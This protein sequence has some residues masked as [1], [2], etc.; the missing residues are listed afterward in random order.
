MCLLLTCTL[1]IIIPPMGKRNRKHVTCTSTA[2]FS[3]ITGAKFEIESVR[4]T[5][6]SDTHLRHACATRTCALPTVLLK[7]GANAHKKYPPSVETIF[8]LF[9]A[10]SSFFIIQS[11]SKLQKI[12]TP[13]QKKYFSFSIL[14]ISNIDSNRHPFGKG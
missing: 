2:P 4:S 6:A 1:F 12:P 7:A 8:S 11:Y 9:F 14:L 5:M 3:Y 13:P 10:D